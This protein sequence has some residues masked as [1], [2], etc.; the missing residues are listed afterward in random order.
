MNFT[1]QTITVPNNDNDVHIKMPGGKVLTIQFR[2]SNAD[3][4]YNGS[5][6][7][8][9]PEDATVTSWKG[10]DM[11]DAP[12]VGE[13]PHIRL[14]KQLA[15]EL[16]WNPDTS[17]PVLWMRLGD[18]GEYES[19]DG[20]A[21]VADSLRES[22]V[23]GISKVDGGISAPGYQGNNYI[24]LYW[25]T[26]ESSDLTNQLSEGEFDDLQNMLCY[27]G[28]ITF[29]K[30][31]ELVIV[32]SYD[33]DTDTTEEHNEV[34]KEGDVVEVDFLRHSE[35]TA[36]FQFGDGSVAFQVPNELFKLTPVE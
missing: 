9:L 10:D 33:E 28:N 16:P 4:N 23:S 18:G 7:I 15:T 34:F 26:A 24:S 12:A 22:N 27:S 2:P 5:L 6:D 29:I 19:F 11:E 14:S 25:G 31:C 21:E 1:E 8:I 17:V 36:D 20:M 35:T 30:D 32:E 3:T 13:H